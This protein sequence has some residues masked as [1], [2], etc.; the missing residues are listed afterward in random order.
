ME[1]ISY[2]LFYPMLFYYSLITSYSFLFLAILFFFIPFFVIP[3]FFIPF[4]YIFVFSL[5]P[6]F[7]FLPIC[8]LR[9]GTGAIGWILRSDGKG[10]VG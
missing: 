5:G 8:S 10:A 2:F 9:A 4:I 6:C 3:F 1:D 7:S